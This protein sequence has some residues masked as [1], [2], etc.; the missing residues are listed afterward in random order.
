M[1][2]DISHRESQVTRKPVILFD[3]TAITHQMKGVGRYAWHLAEQLDRR[4]SDTCDLVVV[5]VVGETPAFPE[6]FRGRVL[7][8]PAASEIFLGLVT[9][10][11][12]VRNFQPVVFVRPADKIGLNY[13]VPTV[14]VCHDLNP[15]IWAQQAPRTPKRRVI[16]AIW[17]WMR[18]HAMRTSDLVVCNSD[19][20]RRAAREAFR[21]D[22]ARLVTAPCGVDRRLTAY[23]D[24]ADCADFRRNLADGVCAE[25]Y[26]LT[27]A[28]GDPR[29]GYD[30]LPAFWRAAQ[31]AGYPGALV[32]AGVNS[33][34][35]YAKALKAAFSKHGAVEQIVWLPF[36]DVRQTEELAKLYA[37]ADFYLEF[38]R[39]EGFGMQLVEAMACG[40][41]CFS[42]GR[43]ALSEVG[44][45]LALPLKREPVASGKAIT[46]AWNQ[47]EHL[48]GREIRKA[49]ARQFDWDIAGKSVADFIHSEVARFSKC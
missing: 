48:R 32:I 38:S 29:E 47:G 5:H 30:A 26:F 16:D 14:T 49:H 1:S 46:E 31:E 20:V 8:V 37:A 43:G 25:G 6:T 9:F 18:G 4:L 12:L 42:T 11:K 7:A 41:A 21:L 45:G 10:S 35:S 39:H 28:T 3:G 36:L 13:L 33:D 27:F 34:S 44:G 2:I 40:T 22:P 23:A 15:L 17:E 19:F 24:V